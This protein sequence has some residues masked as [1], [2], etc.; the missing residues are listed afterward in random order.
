MFGSAG[1]EV[2]RLISHEFFSQNSI[3]IPQRYRQTDRR[4]T[5]LGNIR[6]AMLRAVK[7]V[8]IGPRLF[9]HYYR[10]YH[11]RFRLMPKSTT[12]VDP[13]LTLNGH[14]ALCYI[15]HMYFGA[16]GVFSKIRFICGYS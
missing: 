11:T 15:T 10:K 7:T 8:Q 16:Q 6:S 3:T 14:Y 13:E 4:T 5:C 2:V 1:D 12:L 9:D